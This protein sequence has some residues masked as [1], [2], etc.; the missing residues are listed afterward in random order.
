MKSIHWNIPFTSVKG[1]SYL[2][3]IYD[4]GFTGNQ[5]RLQAGQV[6]FTTEENTDT[7]FFS[8]VRGGTGSISI[9]D[10]DGTIMR[11]LLP[12]NNTSRPVRLMKFVYGV[13]QF[14][15]QGFLTCNTYSQGYTNRPQEVSLQVA[16]LL[17]A[18]DSISAKQSNFSGLMTV[19]QIIHMC[20]AA[21]KDEFGRPAAE[22][23]VSTFY[24]PKADWRIL[25]YWINTSIFFEEKEVSSVSGTT[26]LTVG[27]S[28]KEI[29]NIICTFMGWCVREC[30]NR[31]LSFQ[32]I[33]DQNSSDYLY[34]SY[35]DFADGNKSLGTY[36]NGG[37]KTIE[38][39][40]SLEY[41]GTDHEISTEMGAR[42]VSVI[43]N[44]KSESWDLSLPQAPMIN[45]KIASY[46]T[47]FIQNTT[48]NIRKYRYYAN[49]DEK[50]YSNLAYAYYQGTYDPTYR[51]G[52]YV[53]EISMATF[54]A[55][56]RGM[57]GTDAQGNQY[58]YSNNDTYAG[59]FLCRYY[60]DSYELDGSKL[61]ISEQS[62]NNNALYASFLPG[63]YGS[64][65]TS[66]PIFKMKSKRSLSLGAGFLQLSCKVGAYFIKAGSGA[67]GL[68]YA[69]TDPATP[70]CMDCYPRI[71][72]A[73]RYGNKVVQY[74]PIMHPVNPWYWV[75]G[76]GVFNPPFEGSNFKGNWTPSMNIEKED[77]ILIPI[78]AD[79]EG[80]LMLEFYAEA[81]V[82]GS[83]EGV[84]RPSFYAILF[85]SLEIK[86]IPLT[87]RSKRD[88]A[89]NAYRQLLGLNFNN[90]VSVN[91]DLA[92]DMNNAESPHIVRYTKQTTMEY[93]TY[94][95]PSGDATA[96]PEN[97]L[98][99][100]LAKYYKKRRRTIQ[101][102]VEH[103]NDSLPTTRVIA[104]GIP[105]EPIAESRD[106][107]LD[108]TTVTLMEESAN[109]E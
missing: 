53:G 104:D 97:D 10:P 34:I 38:N 106:Y 85:D 90:E 43:A 54:F 77:G 12:D 105:C 11:S 41:R 47:N 1:D 33:N 46:S 55:N 80:E 45:F 79:M 3:W 6:P 81:D 88:V 93:M 27:K 48:R 60:H 91:T 87:S 82:V 24:F 50:A 36:L 30:P 100:R 31:V 72:F 70:V 5:V 35:A 66:K 49:L 13:P 29:L 64:T 96:R 28:I 22:E 75:E 32:R 95:Y 65:S 8:P 71:K 62:S 44:T 16:S 56:A 61:Y 15:W 99:A 51:T 67:T 107:Q 101:L 20:V 14:V 109:S 58:G 2:L 19:R 74:D 83:A 17:D 86:Y 73:I 23:L 92:S 18:A 4:E 57:F 108:K 42:M 69:L 21:I 59:A 76:G 94:S 39:L 63:I 89:S 102:E 98:L 40:D 78:T 9:I 25:N 68:E 37:T 26:Y 52:T 103:I 7:D 84:D